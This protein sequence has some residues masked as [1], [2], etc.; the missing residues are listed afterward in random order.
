MTSTAAH[1]AWGRWTAATCPRRPLVRFRIAF[2][3][4]WLVY[5]LLD[6]IYAGTA[7]EF[8][9]VPNRGIPHKLAI[10]QI[11][12]IAFE[13]LLL[14]GWRPRI[15]ALA[16]FAVRTYESTFLPLNDFFYFCIIALILSQ[17]DCENGDE[18]A[19]AWPRDLLVLQAAWIYFASS[20]LKLNAP[21]LSGGD[22][23]VRQNYLAT[24]LSWHYPDFYLAWISTLAGN[25]VLAWGAVSAEMSLS[26]VLFGW[27]WF[28]ARAHRFRAAAIVLAVAVHGF[29]AATMNVYFFGMSLV[30]QIVLL[31]E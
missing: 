17:S 30:A 8:W 28:P 11:L 16:A 6:L 5:D 22:L 27:W 21:F 2:A 7:R 1:S 29:A 9:A 23:Y 15:T 25:A 12:L 26:L 18:P 4:I 20:L 3:A 31:T 19:A 14:L 24:A 10:V 13:A